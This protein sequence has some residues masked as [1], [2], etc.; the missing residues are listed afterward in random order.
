MPTAQLGQSLRSFHGPMG[1]MV[2]SN[3][4]GWP[5]W[6]RR[7]DLVG[8]GWFML[9]DCWVMLG[10]P[11]MDHTPKKSASK[12]RCTQL[13]T[14]SSRIWSVPGFIFSRDRDHQPGLPP[15]ICGN[16]V[17]TAHFL[18]M[19]QRFTVQLSS[20][21]SKMTNADERCA[22]QPRLTLCHT[23]IKDHKTK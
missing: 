19:R 12:E 6:W 20:L 10:D 8:S 18:K 17:I 3:S 22:G 23:S 16:L 14:S 13:N 21:A 9:G 15:E 5:S 1:P 2:W 11:S 7:L 4:Y